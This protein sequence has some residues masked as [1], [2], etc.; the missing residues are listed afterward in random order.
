MYRVIIELRPELA[1]AELREIR[2]AI[3]TSFR[4]RAGN[5]SD[6][7]A[8]GHQ[9]IFSGNE[10][11]FGCL[12]LGILALDELPAFHAAALIFRW[13]DPDPDE[14]CDLLTELAAPVY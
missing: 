10:D 2:S 14:S 12:Q 8:G 3:E 13:V 1:G 9:L 7:G 6:S 5:V 4:N 11:V